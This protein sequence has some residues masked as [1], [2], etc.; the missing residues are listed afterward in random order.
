M[1]MLRSMKIYSR[2]AEMGSFTGGAQQ[3][4]VTTA[5]ASR[6]VSELEMHLRT[7]LL[8][9]TTR[10]IALTEA[11][12][13]YLDR[14][15][16]I[17]ESVEIAE[18]EA[19]D[20][21]AL[22]KGNLRI[23]APSAFGQHYVMPALARYLEQ[24]PAVRVDLTLSQQ[25][26][27]LLEDGYDVLLVLATGALPDSGQVSAKLCTMPS[28]LCA[29]PGYL[30]R[31]GTPHSIADLRGHSC[32]QLR[33]AYLASDR[34]IFEGN[35][36]PDEWFELPAGKLRVNS[37][38]ALGAAVRD[39]IGIAPLPLL[40]ALPMLRRGE[41]VRV[42]SDYEL[43]TMTIYAIYSSRE[44]LDAKISTWIACLRDYVNSALV[45]ISQISE[46]ENEFAAV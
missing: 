19:S 40:T 14:C 8:N 11:G 15:R 23:H 27:D 3:L 43:Q 31:A 30:A 2:V 44:Y 22:P 20:A 34:W 42:L 9:R 38:D 28:V 5:Q 13:R 32:L 16:Q 21:R 35:G 45:E 6:A 1:D 39:G 46:R 26:P 18:V 33:T 37:A 12:R 29:S 25:V 4:G 36:V 24:N 41:L 10:R 17:L 7:R